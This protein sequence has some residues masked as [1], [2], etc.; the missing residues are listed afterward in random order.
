[1][2]A[3]AVVLSVE[4]VESQRF[5]PLPRRETRATAAEAADRAAQRLREAGAEPADV[6]VRS[7]RPV[8]TV[9]AVADE[10]DADMILVGSSP[11]R[12]IAQKLL[13]SVALELVQ[14]SPRNVMVISEP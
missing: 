1:M 13:G 2:G 10:V 9:L 3:Q 8:E 6:L 11:R 12:P 5:E 14:R 7:G 4:E